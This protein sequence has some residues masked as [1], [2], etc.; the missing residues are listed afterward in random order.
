MITLTTAPEIFSVLG[1][2]TKV[3]YE[4]MVLSPFSLDPVNQSISGT[5]RLT[6]KLSTDMPAIT[7]SFR[8]SVLAS[9]LVVEVQQL[10]FYR[11][12]VLDG[13]QKNAVLTIIANAQNAIE[14]GLVSLGV[15]AGTQSGGA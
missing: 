6:S 4:K 10:D 3:A 1:G 14:A 7:G 15:V 13:A 5:V 9:E 12:I 8:I 2:S 11:R